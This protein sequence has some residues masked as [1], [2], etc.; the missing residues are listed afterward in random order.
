MFLRR[1]L[2]V[3]VLV[4]PFTFARADDADDVADVPSQDLR[5][6]GDAQKRYFLI[7]PAK[8]AKAPAAGYGLVVILPGGDGSAN[9]HPFVKRI[10]KNSLPEGYIAAQPVSVKWTAAQKIV[11]PTNALE[12]DG[13]KFTTEEFIAAVVEDVGRKHALDRKKVFAL[14]WSSSGPAAYTAIMQEK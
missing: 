2:L 3:T 6:G 8:D 4:L 1:W 11:W 9:F 13:Q 12:A 14:G 7:G 10:F 5:A